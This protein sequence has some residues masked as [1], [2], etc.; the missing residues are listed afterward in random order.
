M[1][2]DREVKYLLNKM[3]FAKPKVKK[4]EKTK[5]TTAESNETLSGAIE[6]PETVSEEKSNEAS[7]DAQSLEDVTDVKKTRN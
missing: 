5:K 3:K 2:L 4:E 1:S 7:R 6:E